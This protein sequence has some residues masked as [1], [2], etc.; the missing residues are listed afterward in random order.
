[1]TPSVKESLVRLGTALPF[2]GGAQLL[3]HFLGVTVSEAT[4]RR[5]TEQA[6]A[7]MAAIQTAM[8]ADLEA[9]QR[10]Y[11][12]QRRIFEEMLPRE[13]VIQF[14]SH[15]T[16]FCC[17]SI[18]EPFGIINL[19]AMACGTPVVASAVGGI[20]EVV[21][22]GETGVLVPLEQQSESPFEPLDRHRFSADLAQAINR[23]LGDAP[24]R[25]RMGRAGRQRVEREFGWPAIAQQ[26]AEL[27][28]SLTRQSPR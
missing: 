25:E 12:T 10:E 20:P 22:D 26:T 1:L 23:L 28:S 15:A 11:E 7:A 2:G 3:T 18:Y 6:G 13:E 19:E 8:V 14:Y 5:A 9:E 24:L 27:Y 4:V 16:V 17:P 21:V